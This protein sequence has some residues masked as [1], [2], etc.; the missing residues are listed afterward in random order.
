MKDLK[1][2][3]RAS[4]ESYGRH[5]L[6]DQNGTGSSSLASTGGG[7]AYDT[8]TYPTQRNLGAAAEEVHRSNGNLSPSKNNGL[9]AGDQDGR[10]TPKREK[11]RM[12]GSAGGK[13]SP[14]IC[15]KCGEPMNG[16]F[17]RA[18]GGIFHLDCFRCS[19]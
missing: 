17:V 18:I 12:N 14:K 8:S 10:D 9:G 3:E 4:M 5:G 13:L 19:V 2:E 1:L 7:T 15:Q 16:Q 6:A 11:S